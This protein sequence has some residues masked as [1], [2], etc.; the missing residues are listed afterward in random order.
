M[1]DV[2]DWIRAI[3]RDLADRSELG[4]GPRLADG[5]PGIALFL[6]H[7]GRILDEPSW[8]AASEARIDRALDHATAADPYLFYGVTGIGWLLEHLSPS[9]STDDDP[10]ADTDTL[11]EV[12]LDQRP[13][14]D[15]RWEHLQGLAGLGV[16]ALERPARPSLDRIIDAIAASAHVTSRGLVWGDEIMTGMAHGTSGVIAF[17]SRAV[18]EVGSAPARQLL[19]RAVPALLAT[20]ADAA[21][22]RRELGWCAGELSLAIALDAAGQALERTEWCDLAIVEALRA[23]HRD[24]AVIPDPGL[25]HGTIGISHVLRRLGESLAS[26][27]LVAAADTWLGHGLAQRS[28]QGIGGVR[29]WSGMQRA[30]IEDPGFLLGA[31]GVGMGL[32]AATGDL[33][34][35]WDHVLGF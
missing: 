11:L 7:A 8:E 3:A 26:D 33:A 5:D 2:R 30:W 17:L 15:G 13:L 4:V 31:A 34:P 18:R 1:N 19:E 28:D 25:C 14:W 20:P 32:L 12:I 9:D 6:G 22:D 35:G 10:N 21:S 24:P 23:A 16:Y 27:E 29:T